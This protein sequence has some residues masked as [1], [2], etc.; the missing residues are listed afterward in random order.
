MFSDVRSLPASGSL[1]SCVQMCSPF[2]IRGRNVVLLRVGAVLRDRTGDQ[3]VAEHVG[4]AAPAELLAEHAP[5]EP[6]GDAHARA[7][8][9]GDISGVVQRA[10]P[11]AQ[12]RHVFGI[13]GHPH[14]DAAASIAVAA[15]ARR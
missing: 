10:H 4:D 6:V 9:V 13:F 1:N 8:L 3:R 7:E 12:L 11:R 2:A 5:F 15:G 14:A